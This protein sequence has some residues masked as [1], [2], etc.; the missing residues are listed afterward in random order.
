MIAL[1]K[2]LARPGVVSVTPRFTCSF[3]FT[4][5]LLLCLRLMYSCFTLI[6]IHTYALLLLCFCFASLYISNCCNP[7][8]LNHIFIYTHTP[9]LLLLLFA[10]LCVC[11]CVCVCVCMLHSCFTP[12]LFTIIYIYIY[13]YILYMLVFGEE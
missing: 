9:T 5:A 11:V 10:C 13:I 1:T 2:L 12:A 4:P 3:C 6:Y 7:T 8:L